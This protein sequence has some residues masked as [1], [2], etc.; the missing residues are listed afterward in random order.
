MY[1]PG[2][3]G[4]C[5]TK[6]LHALSLAQG[7]LLSAEALKD[8]S[9]VWVSRDEVLKDLSVVVLGWADCTPLCWEVSKGRLS[10]ARLNPAHGMQGSALSH[11]ARGCAGGVHM[12]AALLILGCFSPLKCCPRGADCAQESRTCPQPS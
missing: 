1:S 7:C 5:C 12:K 8:P 4:P 9:K 3:E 2:M 10:P 11:A 6:G